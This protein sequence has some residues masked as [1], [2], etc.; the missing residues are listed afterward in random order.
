MTKDQICDWQECCKEYEKTT[1]FKYLFDNRWVHG[2]PEYIAL[3]SLNQWI[4][5]KNVRARFLECRQATMLEF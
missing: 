4:M 1:N 5:G 3:F 2:S